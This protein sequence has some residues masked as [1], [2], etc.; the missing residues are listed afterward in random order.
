MTDY[1]RHRQS[2]LFEI[3]VDKIAKAMDV[4]VVLIPPGS[5]PRVFYAPRRGIVKVKTAVA[6]DHYASRRAG[7]V[8]NPKFHCPIAP[9]CDSVFVQDLETLIQKLY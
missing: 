7:L 1:D 2:Y 5:I 8:W 3:L 6:A 9:M 4:P